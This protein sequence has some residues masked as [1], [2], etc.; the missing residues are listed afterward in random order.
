M[1]EANAG[2]GAGAGSYATLIE[3]FKVAAHSLLT[4]CSEEEFKTHFSDC[5]PEDLKKLYKLFLKVMAAVHRTAEAEFEIICKESK[6]M[7]ELN[8]TDKLLQ[9]LDAENLEKSLLK[10]KNPVLAIKKD[11]IEL[12]SCEVNNLK[13]LLQ[14][15][16]EMRAKTLER[17]EVLQKEAKMLKEAN[18]FDSVA[19]KLRR[20]IQR[21]ATAGEV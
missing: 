4:S 16:E 20:L 2:A 18:P 5:K 19:S 11:A 7:E 10:S 6:V 3:S 1:A 21:G 12:K 17:L 14:Q 13:L 15:E 9:D 8:Y